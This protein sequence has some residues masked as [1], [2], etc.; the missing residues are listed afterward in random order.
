MKEIPIS[1]VRANQWGIVILVL[2]SIFLQ[3]S[4]VIIGLWVIEV[5]GLLWGAKGN[6]FI[7]LL[8]PFLVKEEGR[9]EAAELQRFNNGIAVSLLTI[10]V[11]SFAFGWQLT[12]FIFAS[13]VALAAFIAI[14]GFCIGCVI[15]YQ[16]KQWKLRWNITH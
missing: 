13:F 7:L 3:S 16:Y 5:L 12:G 9:T 6:L 1:F 2:L 10:S 11:L 15:Y 4:W 8:K 14:C